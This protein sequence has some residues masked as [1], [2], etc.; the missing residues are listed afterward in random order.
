MRTEQTYCDWI[1]QFILFH[2]KRHPEE[3]GPAEVRDFLTHLAVARKVAASTQNQALSAL[4][5]LYREVLKR[6]LPWIDDVER[7]KRPPKL[8]VVFTPEEA[9]AVIEQLEGAARTM[10]LLLYGSGLRLMECVRLRVKDVDF[11]YLQITVRDGKGGRDRRTMLPVSLVDA[12]RRQIE[13]R[14]FVVLVAGLG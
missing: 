3:M 6:Q 5:F 2:D 4:L 13:K 7:V 11:G 9:R 12:L 14:R 8:P 10:T 1:R